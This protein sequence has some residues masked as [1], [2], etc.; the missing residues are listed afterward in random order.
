MLMIN[1][2]I[3]NNTPKYLKSLIQLNEGN[4]RTKNKL[5]VELPKNNFNKTTFYIGAPLIWNSIPE[6]IRD[7]KEHDKFVESVKK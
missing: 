5:I 6:E 7:I 3:N 2:I 1:K 4:T